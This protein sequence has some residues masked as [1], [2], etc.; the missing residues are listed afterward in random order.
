MFIVP[1]PLAVLFSVLTLVPK[2]KDKPSGIFGGAMITFMCSLLAV[3]CWMIFGLTWP[4]VATDS[5]FVSVAYLWYAISVI[6][7][8]FT[9]YVALRMLGPTLD[10]GKP[11]L[12]L[13][14]DSDDGEE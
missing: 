5:L 4:A 14:R 6:F 8:V 7:V 13:E 10:T 2:G 1:L 11:R 9:L 12:S 3:I